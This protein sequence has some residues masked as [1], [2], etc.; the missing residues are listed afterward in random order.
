MYK[1]YILLLLIGLFGVSCNKETDLLVDNETS[2]SKLDSLIQETILSVE[3][4]TNADAITYYSQFDQTQSLDSEVIART[5]QEDIG[6][7]VNRRLAIRELN[8][9]SST[10]DFVIIVEAVGAKYTVAPDTSEVLLRM[11]ELSAEDIFRMNLESDVENFKLVENQFGEGI[12]KSAYGD[13]Y[14]EEEWEN[15]GRALWKTYDT[16]E[17]IENRALANDVYN[18]TSSYPLNLYSFNIADEQFEYWVI[19]RRAYTDIYSKLKTFI[20]TY[21]NYKP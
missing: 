5:Q 21:K 1:L 10:K 14:T 4:K 18:S 8:G 12:V 6:K 7:F 2:A 16:Q 20:N 9:L 13:D 15:L 3:S 19:S 17:S 11:V